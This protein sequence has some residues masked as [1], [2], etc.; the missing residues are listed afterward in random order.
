MGAKLEW[1]VAETGKRTEA[2]F[3]NG[4]VLE[5]LAVFHAS[6]SFLSGRVWYGRCTADWR[7]WTGWRRVREHLETEDSNEKRQKGGSNVVVGAR[8]VQVC[9]K[10]A[11]QREWDWVAVAPVR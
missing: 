6:S 4:F 10:E 5:K 9:K 11:V 8:R 7:D 3:R 1:R 2:P